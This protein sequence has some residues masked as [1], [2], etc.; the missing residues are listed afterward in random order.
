MKWTIIGI[1]LF[2]LSSILLIFI[3]HS[4]FC[5]LNSNSNFHN[6]IFTHIKNGIKYYY[7]FFIIRP[8]ILLFYIFSIFLFLKFYFIKKEKTSFEFFSLFLI[9]C[10]SFVIPS[11][12]E[13]DSYPLHRIL[14]PFFPV[15]FLLLF[16][17]LKIEI[18]FFK[19]NHIKILFLVYFFSN[20]FN[21]I[22]S[23]FNKKQFY[24][25]LKPHF[26]IASTG[27]E[28]GEKLNNFFSTNKKHPTLGVV[29]FFS[30]KIGYKGK[31][32]E[33]ALSKN[34]EVS[35]KMINGEIDSIFKTLFSIN[36]DILW[37]ENCG[38]KN[39]NDFIERKMKI[40]FYSYKSLLLESLSDT[41]SF[42]V[43][44]KIP[45]NG[46]FSGKISNLHTSPEFKSIYGF[47]IIRNK[48]IN[49]YILH[50]FAKKSF[51]KTLDKSIFQVIEF[52]FE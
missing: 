13:G 31:F 42:P 46:Y 2:L 15:Y 6:F 14:I 17:I 12:I 51:I 32:I 40:Y 4:L 21:P 45:R 3:Q 44:I 8:F 1:L 34:N 20:M 52:P 23:W 43:T 30:L 28:V 33:L 39:T 11:L 10:Y 22:E 19:Y 7:N 25:P 48:Y 26:A 35:A 41:N 9:T 49:D 27:R 50:I 16:E 29:N 18:L 24:Y 36:P 47:F 38:F 5:K 37:Y